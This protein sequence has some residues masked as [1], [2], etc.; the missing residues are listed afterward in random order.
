MKNK[1]LFPNVVMMY[2]GVNIFQMAQKNI[3]LKI[4]AFIYV[5]EKTTS[6]KSFSMQVRKQQLEL[7][8]EQQT[9]S[10]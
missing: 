8:M 9:V 1:F 3:E 4:K 10:K 7:G 6:T 2:I 5:A